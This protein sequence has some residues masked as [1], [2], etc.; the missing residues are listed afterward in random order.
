GLRATVDG[1]RSLAAVEDGR[2]GGR[3]ELGDRDEAGDRDAGGG[4]QGVGLVPRV[5]HGRV[6]SLGLDR[7]LV[8]DTEADAA[9]VVGAGGDRGV[10]GVASRGEVAERDADDV[11]GLV[12]GQ[13]GVAGAVVV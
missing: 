4:G 9:D 10:D 6:A 11:V 5:L 8:L 1:A 3:A 7:V 13:A 12:S 2:R